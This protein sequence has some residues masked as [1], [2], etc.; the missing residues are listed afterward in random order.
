MVEE[1]KDKRKREQK[2]LKRGSF[3]VHIF[4]LRHSQCSHSASASDAVR[5]AS[6]RTSDNNANCDGARTAAKSSTDWDAV[7]WQAASAAYN[8]LGPVDLMD[9]WRYGSSSRLRFGTRCH[10]TVNSPNFSALIRCGL[11]FRWLACRA[12]WSKLAE[13]R[14][15]NS[16]H[17]TIRWNDT[18]KVTTLD[19]MFTHHCP[20]M[21][22]PTSKALP[23]NTPFTRS[24]KH[25]ANVK[26]K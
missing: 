26:Q 19:K 16:C 9:F 4:W 22:C 17:S 5:P 25:R 15:L 7:I 10:I 21:R 3:P 1:K 12:Q 13:V 20:S 2:K 18:Y 11:I 23:T 8:G 6:Q 14:T 24:S